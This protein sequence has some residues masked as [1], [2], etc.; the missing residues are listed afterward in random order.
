MGFRT[1]GRSDYWAFGKMGSHPPIHGIIFLVEMALVS[2]KQ[3]CRLSQL[4]Q[5]PQWKINNEPM[6]HRSWAGEA[7][8]TLTPR[9]LILWQCGIWISVPSPL[10]SPRKF[11]IGSCKALKLLPQGIPLGDWQTTRPLCPSRDTKRWKG[12]AGRAC[13]PHNA[14]HKLRIR[15]ILLPGGRDVTEVGSY[16]SICCV[17]GHRSPDGDAACFYWTSS[18]CQCD[19]RTR[20]LY[21]LRHVSSGRAVPLKQ[22]TVIAYLQSEQLLLFVDNYCPPLQN[23]RGK[24]ETPLCDPLMH[25]RFLSFCFLI[26]T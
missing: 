6:R 10:C 18:A 26:S 5:P 17:C 3:M 12:T 8:H 9:W 16:V 4:Y 11:A 22:T 20:G 1:N 21:S 15:I 24:H 23:K 25:F 7:G 14:D 19:G 13:H 2:N